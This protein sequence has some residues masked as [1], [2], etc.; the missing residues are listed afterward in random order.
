[1]L[2]AL[3]TPKDTFYS[4]NPSFSL[5]WE[6]RSDSD[7][8]FG[9]NWTGTAYGLLTIAALTPSNYKIEIIDENREEINFTK[10]FDLVG[11][12]AL[13]SHIIRAYQIADVFRS[14]GIKVI[15]GGLHVTVLPEE[16]KLHAD[17]IAVGEGEF[18]WPKILKD[19]EKKQLCSVYKADRLANLNESPTPRYDLIQKYKYGYVNIQTSRG[20]PHDCEFCLGSNV[21]GKKYRMK[22]INQVA[23]EIKL[24]K[25][26][27]GDIRINFGDDN[28]LVNK[29]Y[30]KMLLEE[31]GKLNIRYYLQ[32]DIQIA[33]H[34]ELLLLLRQSG[35]VNIFIGFETIYK[36]GLLEIDKTGWKANQLKN[37][38]KNI[39][40]IQ[41]LGI[42]ILGAF[43]VGLDNDNKSI[44]ERINNFI[45]DNYI[46]E[47]QITILTP[48]P[49]TKLRE[50]L[51]K[52]HRLLNTCW[53]NYSMINV[54]YIHP[55][56]TTEEIETGLVDIYKQIFQEKIILQKM[57]Y[58]KKIHKNLIVSGL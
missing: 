11:I 36:E 19:F 13:T 49:G 18:V 45:I 2:I 43:I 17:A 48:L 8:F 25:E 55:N 9:Q 6:K 4:M 22:S 29:K 52:E 12:S 40:K 7:S 14:K 28:M 30:A 10:S 47:S 26:I 58:F 24:I 15:L 56:M 57:E 23:N 34:K 53:N 1:M 44:F 35:C 46:F 16:A 32:S 39:N 42:G 41:S 51:I 3:I 54:N 38:S 21:Y 33:E 37:Y 27:F 20:C 50:R 31:I 5:F